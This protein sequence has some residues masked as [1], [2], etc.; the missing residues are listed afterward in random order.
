LRAETQLQHVYNLKEKEEAIWEIR[1]LK[2]L[3]YSEFML[4]NFSCIN[5][6]E[7]RHDC[8]VK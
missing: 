8:A 3:D 5:V 1:M 6:S 4:K 2:F 7:Y